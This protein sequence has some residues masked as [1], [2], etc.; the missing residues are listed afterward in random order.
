M[1]AVPVRAEAAGPANGELHGA[2]HGIRHG[3]LPREID[4][5]IDAARSFVLTYIPGMVETARNGVLFKDYKTTLQEIVQKSREETISYAQDGEEGPD[6]DK[7]FH[8]TLFINS[9][10]FSEGIG[11]SK[12]E[13]EQNAAREALILMGVEKE[14]K[15]GAE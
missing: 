6:H 8:V 5:G 9:N 15:S 2:D 13:A 7:R 12:K 4:G 11:R 1:H 3:I 14:E 10:P